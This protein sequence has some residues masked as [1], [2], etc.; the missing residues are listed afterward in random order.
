[1]N[2]SEKRKSWLI[3]CLIFIT[4]AVCLYAFIAIRVQSIFN[5]GVS[6]KLITG[7]W[8][9]TKYGE[10]YYFNYIKHFKEKNIPMMGEKFQFSNQQASLDD[11]DII[12][13]GDSFFDICRPV[14]YPAELSKRLQKKVHFAY[15][16]YPLQ[17]LNKNHY[18][19]K[20]PKILIMG[21]VERYIPVKFASQHTPDYTIDTQSELHKRISAVKDMVFN[22][23]SEEL[24]DA[25][26][27][28]SYLTTAVYSCIA[29]IK[30]D[31]FGYVSK[32][33]P[34]Y[35]LNDTVPWMF[36]H[37]EVN[38]QITSFYY[39]HTDEEMERVSNNILDLSKQLK[40]KYNIELIF[41]PIPAKYTLYHS[42]INND[43]YSNYLPELQRKFEE[44]GIKYIDFYDSFI[45]SKELLYIPTDGHWNQNGLELGV[46][47]TTN[48]LG[49][50]GYL[51]EKQ[52]VER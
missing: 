10:L 45:Q 27:K 28:R 30:F 14:Q 49:R 13:F 22:S 40:E 46:Q 5:L 8:D 43:Q 23:R 16:D 25:L 2:L 31:L 7:Y 39:H 4:G 15:N 51:K 12:I 11:A 20:T 38:G 44:K 24:F 26:L 9:N 19:S 17:Y 33:T 1:M 36:Y 32:L 34:K 18:Q 6:E 21:I 37:D 52:L 3:K 47:L 48:Y 42:K 50:N 29:T 35:Y 41:I